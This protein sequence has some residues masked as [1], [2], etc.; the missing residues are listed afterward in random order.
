MMAQAWNRIRGNRSQEYTALPLSEKETSEPYKPRPERPSRLKSVALAFQVVVAILSVYGLINVVR[1]YTNKSCDTIDRGYRCSPKTT[2]F[3]GQ[4]SLWYSV[5]SEIDVAPPKGCDV[6]FANVLSRHGGRDP[7]I[8]KSIA[9]ALL[10]AQIHNTSSAYPGK[11]K[12]LQDYEYSLGADQLTDAGRQEMVNS[13]AHFFRRYEKLVKK[14]TPFVRAGGQH[15]VIES[16]EKWLAGIA[17]SL[18]QKPNKVDLVIPEGA[19]W[20]NTLSHGACPAFEGGPSHGLGE[21]A[22][23][24]WAS[25]FIPPIQE[26][27]NAALGTNLGASSIVYLM[28]MCPYDTVASPSATMS[29]FCHLFTEKEWH[30]YD[31]YQTLG[32]FYGYSVGNPL[33]ATQG[34]GYVNELLARLTGTPV[35]DN[36]NT[37][38]TLDSDPTTF[39][40]D[41]KVYADF[42]H[43]NDMS[44]IFAALGLYNNTDLLS[45]TTIESTKQTYGYSAAWTV[46][47]AARLYIEKLQCKHEPEEFV[48]IIV[49]DRVHPLEFCD[50]DKYGRCTLSKFVESQSFSR[51][52][53]NW[54]S[55]YD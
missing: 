28:D 2:H 21:R 47:F 29:Q 37:N 22:Q 53:G 35:Q 25:Y 48:R 10:I 17:Q 40:L 8:G 36:T 43:D 26:R 9:Y 19:Q 34:I 31:Y 52:G 42:S 6:T 11:F 20:N 12:F 44:G 13:G 49:N 30:A 5:P 54:Q 23:R 4:Y 41:R 45:N 46:P 33:G 3:W 14:H 38:R 1:V 50:G 18:K 27:V 16:A 24:I 39:P 15:R 32:K 51:N 55:C 7:T